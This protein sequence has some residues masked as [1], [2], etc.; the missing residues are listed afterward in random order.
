MKWAFGCA[1]I[2]KTGDRGNSDH[3][4]GHA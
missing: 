4:G 2:G 3:M 1:R